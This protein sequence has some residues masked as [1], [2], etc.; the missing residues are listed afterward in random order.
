MFGGRFQTPTERH[1]IHVNKQSRFVSDSAAVDDFR[2]YRRLLAHV[3]PYKWGFVCAIVGMLL[4]SAGDASIVVMLQPI[5]DD[6]FVNR[7]TSFIQWVPLVLIALGLVRA[8]GTFVDG[9]CMSWVARRVIQD[10][11]QLMFERLIHAPVDY[12]DQSSSGILSARLI[13]NV[14]QVAAASTTAVRG[15]FRDAFKALFLLVWMFYLSWKLSLLFAIIL[16]VAY[17]VFKLSSSRFRAISL[18]V[19]ESVGGIL[20]VAKEALHGQRVIKIFGAYDY[21]RRLFLDANNRNRQQ[22][23]KATAVSSASVPLM[24]FLSGVGV[25]GVIWVALQQDITP[26]VFSSYLAAMVMTT[27][28]IRSLSK[29]NLVI[30]GGLAGAQSVFDTIDLEQEPDQGVV[31]LD[32]VAGDVRF[33]KVSFDYR[34]GD[35][36]VLRDVDIDIKAGTTV[37]LVGVSGSGKST[38]ASLLLRFYAP[39]SG[40]ISIDG[41]PL[42]TLTLDSLRANTAIV[43]QEIILFDDTIGNNIAYGEKSKIDAH[44]QLKAATAA[45]VMEF[46]ETMADGLD[47]MI[48][49]QGIRL[50]GGQRQRIAIARAL[51][52]DAPLLIMDEATSSLDSHSEAH[53]QD[54]IARLVKNRTSLII[55]HRLSTIEN[56]DLILV[57]ENGRIVQQGRHAELLKKRGAYARLHRAQH[58]TQHS[59]QHSKQAPAQPT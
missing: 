3:L 21:Q 51:Y 59:A 17:I 48:G 7:D 16:P 47:T 10:L 49:E 52:K 34:Q 8:A 53:I 41:K 19:Q 25:A 2:L 54:A 12:Y 33:N 58:S 46:V 15:L 30:Q 37:A 42:D 26:G 32:N 57:L 50:S 1:Y 28:P 5:I 31:V 40:H 18:R 55:A 29:I 39:T 44:K 45:N 11:R 9:Y 4:V 38:I 20:H 23:M 13:Y 22:T 35:K 24:V 6:G 36:P 14:E 56:A 43:T 27:K